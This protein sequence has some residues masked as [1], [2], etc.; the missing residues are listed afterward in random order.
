M[1]MLVDGDWRT[2]AYS[3][4]N[5]EGEYDRDESVFRDQIG[6]EYPAEPGRYHLYIARSCPWAHGTVLV[7]TLTGLWDV[8]SMDILDPYRESDG[9]QFSPDREGCTPDTVNGFSYLREAY[10]A[11]DPGY[12][13]RV[14]VPVLWDKQDDTIVNNESIEIMQMLDT[15]FNEYKTRDVTLY[16]EDLREEIDEIVARMYEAINNGVYRAGFAETQAAYD[17]AVADIFE[18]FEQWETVLD[19]QRFLLGDRLTLADLRLFA[20]LVRFDAVY[21][22]HFKCN[23]KRIVDYPNLWNYTKDIYQ[24]PGVADT[25]NMNHITEHYYRSHTSLNPKQIIPAGPDI[26]FTETHNRNRLQGDPPEVI[27]RNEA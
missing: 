26:D 1:A 25:V 7:R 6:R 21:H 2:D 13:G 22:T 27:G 23:V 4:T 15:A 24:L 17:R 19:K 18:A 3:S 11:A 10:Q 12:T 5:E 20:T 16:P 9:W 8:I 14:T